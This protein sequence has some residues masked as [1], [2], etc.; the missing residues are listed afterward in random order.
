MDDP[1][2]D[3][4]LRFIRATLRSLEVDLHSCSPDAAAAVW[5]AIHQIE[6]ARHLLHE[7]RQSGKLTRGQ[8]ARRIRSRLH[9]VWEN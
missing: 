3:E 7:S 6:F 9:P 8:Q 5:S 4:E 1:F 2:F